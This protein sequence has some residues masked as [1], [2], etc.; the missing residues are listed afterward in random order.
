M[1]VNWPWKISITD[2]NWPQLRNNYIRLDILDFAS[3]LSAL[4]TAADISQIKQI[5]SAD[6]TQQQFYNIHFKYRN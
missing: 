3:K 5:L 6:K 4:M 2:G 1:S